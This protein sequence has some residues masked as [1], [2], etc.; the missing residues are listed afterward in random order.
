MAYLLTGC[1]SI[2]CIYGSDW[3]LALGIPL[4]QFNNS[5]CLSI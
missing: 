5:P 3:N 2:D 1:K 4:T